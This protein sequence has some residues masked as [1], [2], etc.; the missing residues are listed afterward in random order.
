MPKSSKYKHEKKRKKILIF[1]I[2]IIAI[3]TF[4]HVTAVYAKSPF[5]LRVLAEKL[6]IVKVVPKVSTKLPNDVQKAITEE[7][8]KELREGH[9]E[10]HSDVLAEVDPEDIEIAKSKVLPDNAFYTFKRL[11]RRFQEFFTFDSLAKTQLILKHNS[12]EMVETLSLLQKSLKEKNPIFRNLQINI[13]ARELDRVENRFNQVWNI[14]EKTGKTDKNKA[15]AISGV[16]FNYA[17]KFFRQELILQE[18]EDKL[19]VSSMIKIENARAKRLGIFAKI[20]TTYHPDP[21]I[22]SRELAN[23]LSPETGTYYKE[24]KTAELLQEIEDAIDD[25]NQRASLRLSQYI[26]I[27]RFEK[28]VLKLPSAKR[29]ELLATFVNR[30]YGNPMREFKTFTR[31]RRV[32]QSRELIVFSE[33][34]KTKILADFEKRVLG[35]TTSD[36]QNQFIEIWVKDPA[37]LRILEALELRSST[38]KNPSPKLA[39]IVKSLKKRALDKISELY[40]DNPEKLKDTL[41]YE[42]ATVYPDVLDVKVAIDLNNSLEDSKVSADLEQKV[43][44]TFVS[45]LPNNIGGVVVTHTSEVNSIIDEIRSVI[46]A[47]SLNEFSAAVEAEITIDSLDVPETQEAI[48]DLV[49]EL[50]QNQNIEIITENLHVPIEETISQTDT[51]IIEPSVEQVE[52]RVEQITE[53]IFSE[54][55]GTISPVEE[56]LP[57]AIQQE[58]E[59]IQETTTET[60]QVDPGLVE[61]VVNTVEQTTPTIETTTT[62]VVEETPPPSTISVPA[63]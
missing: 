8:I 29:E 9:D 20:L 18:L 5:T 15:R 45:N 52:E 58:I 47:S 49:N 40:K 23:S 34:Y 57:P 59:Q 17:E 39:G 48:I 55:A 33:L 38:E 7:A 63:L 36:L 41:F 12:W 11:G 6:G 51:T 13:S 1:L 27:E 22:L 44:V 3:F 42:S 28:K 35:L 4:L 62:T 19:D 53:E 21:Q 30:I 14:V 25:E 46:P 32:F 31:V 60:P 50:E 2:S 61:T 54:P 16:T 37:D 10:K 24:L 56:T 26:L 43:V